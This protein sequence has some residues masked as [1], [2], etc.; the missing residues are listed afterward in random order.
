MATLLLA[1]EST[2]MRISHPPRQLARTTLGVLFICALLGGSGWILSPFLPALL[3]ATMIVVTTWPLMLHLQQRFGNRRSV[4]T[5]LM[6]LLIFLLLALPLSM[7]ITTTIQ[8]SDRIIEWG[9]SLSHVTLPPLPGWI[10]ELPQIGRLATQF[11]ERVA[12]TGTAELATKAAPYAGRLTGWFVDEVGNFGMLLLQFLLTVALSAVFFLSGERYARGLRSFGYRLGGEQGDQ[13]IVLAGKA[14]RAVALG[15]GITALVQALL[16]GI[17]LAIAG[18][19]LA[20]LLT[21]VMFLL[22][23]A[24][25]GPTPVLLLAILWLYWNDNTGWAIFL[26]VW[27]LIVISLDNFLRPV[28]IKQGADL[29][30]LLIIAGVIGG[31]FAFG[32]VGIFVGPVVLAVSFTLLQAWLNEVPAVALDET[33]ALDT[34]PSLA[35]DDSEST[36]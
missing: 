30:M 10:G 26:L 13:A 9:K 24:Q 29:P 34:A 14:I 32:L 16:G 4:A 7:A 33:D 6:T 35:T 23:I 20:A 19:P 21:M 11:W 5:A 18:V 2:M 25:I 22:C 27:S 8:N 28:L 36:Y 1:N 31:L 12:N 15:V 17:G 3:W